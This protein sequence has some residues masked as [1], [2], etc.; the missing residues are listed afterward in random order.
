MFPEGRTKALA[1][2]GGELSDLLVVRTGFALHFHKELS[3]AALVQVLLDQR[4]DEFLQGEIPPIRFWLRVAFVV[5]LYRL[6]HAPNSPH[7]LHA[8]ILS[9]CSKPTTP[10]RAARSLTKKLS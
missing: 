9:G 5:F 4:E 2:R 1:L 8:A 6:A 3:S 7:Q 10:D